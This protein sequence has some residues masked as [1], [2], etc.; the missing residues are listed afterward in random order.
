MLHWRR[1]G[2]GST[3]DRTAKDESAHYLGLMEGDSYDQVMALTMSSVPRPVGEKSLDKSPTMGVALCSCL[4]KPPI[5]LQIVQ[6]FN[7]LC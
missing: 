6:K 7:R 1:T 3:L 2:R 5:P 4:K